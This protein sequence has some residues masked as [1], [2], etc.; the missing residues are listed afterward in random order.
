MEEVIEVDPDPPLHPHED[1][2]LDPQDK[3]MSPTTLNLIL[4]LLNASQFLH[5]WGRHY[6]P[7][8][9][10]ESTGTACL[11]DHILKLCIHFDKS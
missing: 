9:V 5:Q 6:P 2:Q 1:N 4:L 3:V 10:V 7:E 8:D 11:Q